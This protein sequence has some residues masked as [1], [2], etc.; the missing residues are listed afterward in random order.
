MTIVCIFNLIAFN[1]NCQFDFK[2]GKSI[3]PSYCGEK[4]LLKIRNNF[5]GKVTKLKSDDTFFYFRSGITEYA[6]R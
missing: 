3:F 2:H 5:L 1:S 4:N 6:Y